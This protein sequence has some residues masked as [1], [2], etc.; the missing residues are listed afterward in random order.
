MPRFFEWFIALRYLRSKRR[1]AFVSLITVISVV[2]VAAG[3]MALV[4]ALAVN[5]GFHD[6]LQGSLLEATPHVALLEK[7]PSTGIENWR[8][9]SQ[10][11]RAIPGVTS[12]S[13]A[14]YGKVMLSGPL[15]SAEATLK[16][17]EAGDALRLKDHLKAGSIE[18]LQQRGTILL[19]SELAKRLGQPVNSR[20][21]LVSPQGEVTPFGPRISEIPMRVVG[22]FETGFYDLDN[23]FAVVSLEEAQ[24]IF[25]TGDVVNT[26]ELRLADVDTA[27]AVAKQA[28][29]LAGPELG[30]TTWMEQNRQILGALQMEKAV[31]VITISLIQLVAALNVL[32]AL[33]L[34]VMEKR[35]DVAI[36]IS[37][38]ARADQIARVFILQGL[39]IAFTGIAIGLTA[40][41]TLAH[42]ADHY[43]WIPLDAAV[44]SLNYVPF[45]PA[46]TDAVWI[47]GAALLVTL[48]A[49]FYPARSAAKTIP[50]ETLRY[51]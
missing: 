19:G 13:A 45:H 6:N 40:G 47:T 7:Q 18:A 32:T 1:Q 10:K 20:L 38:G 41:Y 3:V 30:A 16:G 15:Q 4:I 29:A 2:G 24:R 51:E 25:V 49:T 34:I 26:L 39:L 28:E 22:I 33:V 36:L 44:Y 37:L 48:L 9:L 50:V 12:A 42:L 27:P 17:V 11:L 46:W 14:L 43:R 35:R 31:S 21:R 8:A 5:N 23:E